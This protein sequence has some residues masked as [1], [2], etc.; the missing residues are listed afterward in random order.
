MIG[1][2]ANL[3]DV[4]NLPTPS[5]VAV[6]TALAHRERMRI[7]ERIS[8]GP[9]KQ[10]E[11]AEDLGLDSGSLSRWL[12]ELAQARIIN[13]DREGSHDPYW[14]VAPERTN[15][16]LDLVALLAS[17]LA[18]AYANRATAQAEVDKARLRE[19]RKRAND[20]S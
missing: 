4:Q 17:E 5:D 19:R 1:N 7:V 15:E 14:L 3:A 12:R 2:S 8:R 10:K 18:D 11:L 20:R 16:L 6:L 9:A 13:Q